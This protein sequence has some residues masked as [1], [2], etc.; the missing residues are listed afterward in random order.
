MEMQAVTC[1]EEDLNSILAQVTIH[2][3]MLAAAKSFRTQCD[4]CSSTDYE[5]WILENIPC[6][7]D[8]I[9][10]RNYMVEEFSRGL[11]GEDLDVSNL[12]CPE[13]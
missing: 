5:Q 3:D 12:Q 2:Q 4:T 9:V 8:G 11:I 1:T 6:E 10:A 13:A 7:G